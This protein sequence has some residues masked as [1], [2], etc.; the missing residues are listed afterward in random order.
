M[1]INFSPSWIIPDWPAPA[2][3]HALLTTRQ[4]GSSQGAYA[5]FNLALHVADDPLHVL[6]NRQALIKQA[7]LPSEPLWIK[8]VHGT[9]VIN[10]G[11]HSPQDEPPEADAAVAFESGQVC[12]VF[13]ADCLPILLCN[14]VGTRVAAIHAGW[15]GLAAGVI[16]ATAET[17][18]EAPENLMAYLGPAISAKHFEVG[19]KVFEAFK[20][21]ERQKAFVETGLGKWHA[22][23][24][25]LARIRLKKIGVVQ[26]Y[27][28]AY[29]TYADARR[30]YS[31]RRSGV[32]GR[33]ASL[34]WLDE[35][36]L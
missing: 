21:D 32:T 27:G 10:V 7:H 13:S 22:D 12:A 26:V 11:Q 17:L 30:F 23:L 14:R 20:A 18:A 1:R 8:Q 28:G 31:Y 16:E 33:M 19:E 24:Y 2:H 35:E 3:V 9:T 15:S 34:I 36:E 6:A 4:R 25:E 29:C 5:G